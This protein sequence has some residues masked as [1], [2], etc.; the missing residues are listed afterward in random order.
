MTV[1]SVEMTDASQKSHDRKTIALTSEQG[2]RVQRGRQ[3]CN[4]FLRQHGLNDVGFAVADGQRG[5]NGSEIV[6]RVTLVWQRVPLPH[7][8]VAVPD[9]P[10]EELFHRRM[11]ESLL[12]VL[13]RLATAATEVEPGLALRIM[14]A[15]SPYREG[16]E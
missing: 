9:E 13:D 5:P 12:C 7:F 15:I 4:T 16:L 3:L 2:L 11:I 6:D 1:G 10:D 8:S 14:A